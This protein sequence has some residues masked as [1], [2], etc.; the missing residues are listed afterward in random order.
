MPD[1]ANKK[2]KPEDL[3]RGSVPINHYRHAEKKGLITF[4]AAEGTDIPPMTTA[5]F[6]EGAGID[7]NDVLGDS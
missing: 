4:A 3:D 7:G 5:F 1:F 6:C 2:L